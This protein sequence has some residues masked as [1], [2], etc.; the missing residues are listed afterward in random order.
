MIKDNIFSDVC[1]Y[2][3]H[4]KLRNNSKNTF[5]F[6][7]LDISLKQY[8]WNDIISLVYFYIW[9]SVMLII[10]YINI[11]ICL[12]MK[13][14]SPAS[15]KIFFYTRTFFEALSIWHMKVS[16]CIKIERWMESME[17]LSQLA[18]KWSHSSECNKN[19]TRHFTYSEIHLLHF[20]I[21]WRARY[22]S[23]NNIGQ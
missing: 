9:M 18:Q 20:P 21:I 22:Y 3:R 12:C 16:W 8:I 10:Y 13:I 1:N 15:V 4:R 2:A 11:T 14:D 5:G 23:V 17:T 6:V 7:S 19:V